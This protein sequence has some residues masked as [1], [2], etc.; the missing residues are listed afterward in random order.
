MLAIYNK[1]YEMNAVKNKPHAPCMTSYGTF[2]GNEII[3]CRHT[4]RTITVFEFP[5]KESW[6]SRVSFEFLYGIWV[7][8]P[9]T[10]AEITLPRVANDKLIFVASFSLCPVAPVFDWRSE[11]CIHI[12]INNMN[13]DG[14]EAADVGCVLYLAVHV[15]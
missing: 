14:G 6:R 1:Q 7:L 4:I 3:G 15:I 10:R 8:L 13:E 5:P 12:Q 2:L 11:P 9:S